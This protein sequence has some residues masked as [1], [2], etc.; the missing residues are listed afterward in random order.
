MS[1]AQ[2]KQKRPRTGRGL[3]VTRKTGKPTLL[4][5]QA[6]QTTVFACDDDGG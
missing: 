5:L 6:D 1:H 2:C 4:F 3:G